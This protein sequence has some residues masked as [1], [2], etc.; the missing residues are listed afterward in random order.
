M[1]IERLQKQFAF[2]LEMDKEKQ[3]ERRTHIHGYSRHETDAE[4]AWHMALMVKIGR[5][6]V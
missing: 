6:H 1:D 2:I 3:I 4:H 5:A